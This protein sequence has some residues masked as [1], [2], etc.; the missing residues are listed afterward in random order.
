MRT[1]GWAAYR[2][3]MTNDRDS[4]GDEQ[5][6]N[7]FKGTP[8]EQLF[9]GGGMGSMMGGQG[10]DLNSMMQQIQSMMQPHEGPLNWE[11]ATDLARKQV[12]A[13]GAD[14][15]PTS[16]QQDAVADAI[17]LA[18]HWL[19]EATDYPSGVTS[20][21]AW[22]RS[23]WIHDT[24]DTW[25]GLVE[26]VAQEA[27]GSAAHALPDEAKQMAGPL[28]DIIGRAVGAM[29]ASQVGTALGGLAGEVLTSTDIGLPLGPEKHAALLPAN[30]TAFAEG[31]D[32]SASDVLLF[33][34]LREAA[35]QRLFAHVPWLREHLLDSVRDFAGGIKVN[36]ENLQGMIEERMRG[37]DPSNPQELQEM[38]EG[39]M[40]E[41]PES[42]QQKAAL[43]RLEVTLAL[44]EGWVDD[45]VTQATADRMPAAGKLAESV[46]RRR[47]AGGPA[48]QT[49]G[50]LVGME[51]R[52]RRMR[53]A[54]ALWGSLRTRQGIEGRD[55]VWL[56]SHLL[57]T[58]TD[59]D[60]P[61]GFRADAISVDDISEDEFDSALRDLLD[62][63]SGN[64][65]EE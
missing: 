23:D 57:P 11:V 8:F 28:I 37:I 16:K 32:V 10:F 22:S 2:G 30:V 13:A 18:D 36:T 40:F 56:S 35:H 42:P 65:S 25:R 29:L 58:S 33:F 3:D 31:L 53:D 55:G 7:P 45:V 44:V 1:L 12:A 17:R 15:T 48:E 43:E 21:A 26:P 19:D 47:A 50:A 24:Q 63:E 52:P 39:G 27:V 62:S 9:S 6:E 64:E 5:G 59:L 61:L 41:M 54:A 49:F 4:S 51:L 60:D 20:S 34:A 14:P 46:R 38:L